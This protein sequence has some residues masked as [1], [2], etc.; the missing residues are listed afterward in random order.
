MIPF[1]KASSLF[2][3]QDLWSA[4]VTSDVQAR[5]GAREGGVRASCLGK[6]NSVTQPG[7]SGEASLS[8]AGFVA[9]LG[10][11]PVR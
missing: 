5:G 9:W 2:L 4:S 10:E 6:I 8:N 3:M 7:T 1:A 11:R